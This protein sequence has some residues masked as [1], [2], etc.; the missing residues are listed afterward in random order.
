[1]NKYI[2]NEFNYP[3]DYS[4]YNID[5][6]TII[7]DF[8]D[9]IV[10]CYLSG[11]PLETYKEKYLLFKTIVK[12]KSEENKIY[13]DFKEETNFNGYLTTKEMRNGTTFIKL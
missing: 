1:M 8:L 5:E 12:S 10:N 11:V 13:K 6:I 4:L 3:L 7:I 2:N 9:T